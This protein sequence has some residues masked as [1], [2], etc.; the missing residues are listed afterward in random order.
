LALSSKQGR[1]KDAQH[2][3]TMLV[4]IQSWVLLLS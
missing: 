3:W 4:Q 1:I 2:N